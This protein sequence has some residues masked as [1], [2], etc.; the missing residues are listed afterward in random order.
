MKII[1]WFKRNCSEL[2]KVYLKSDSVNETDNKF[3][4]TIPIPKGFNFWQGETFV[5]DGI[6]YVYH[7]GFFYTGLLAD[8][9]YHINK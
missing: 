3:V 9:Y 7:S 5:H 6:K 8:Q 4:I 1:E 2:E